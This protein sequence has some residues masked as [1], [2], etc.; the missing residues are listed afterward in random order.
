MSGLPS[1]QVPA[2]PIF[3][4][5][6]WI[7]GSQYVFSGPLAGEAQAGF[8]E[9]AAVDPAFQASIDEAADVWDLVYNNMIEFISPAPWGGELSSIAANETLALHAG[10]VAQDAR[11]RP[12]PRPLTNSSGASMWSTSDVRGMPLSR[13]Q[14]FAYKPGPQGGAVDNVGGVPSVSVSREVVSSGAFGEVL[15]ATADLCASGDYAGCSR[16]ELYHDITGNINSPQPANTSIGPDFREAIYHVV[17]GGQ[18]PERMEGIYYP[19]GRNSYLSESAYYMA[20]GSFGPRYWGEENYA[21]L[22]EVKARWDPE[23]VFW[24][25]HCVGDTE[26]AATRLI[27]WDE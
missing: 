5:A 3:C 1:L 20:P 11:L 13:R 27:S 22:L 15:K 26:E 25:H 17:V 2:G 14:R 18:S 12:Q 23:G 21:D 24:C 6:T 19:L 8:D 9:I 10:I 7:L 4:G 16:H